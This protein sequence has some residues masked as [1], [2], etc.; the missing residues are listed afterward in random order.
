MRRRADGLSGLPGPHRL[1][2]QGARLPRRARRGRSRARGRRRSPA[3]RRC[4]ART[5]S[6]RTPSAT[7]TLDG[8]VVSDG[9]LPPIPQ[10]RR[11]LAEKLPAYMVP[12]TITEI[13][14]SGQRQRKTGCVRAPRTCDGPRRCQPRRFDAGTVLAGIAAGVFGVDD[15]APTQSVLISVRIRCN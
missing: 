12:S 15:V 11:Q 9:A 5:D 3:R 10:I 8:Y 2:G 1:P 6:A 7:T 4:P 13:D 14:G